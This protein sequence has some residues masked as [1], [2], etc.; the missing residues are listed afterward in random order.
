MKRHGKIAALI[1]HAVYTKLISHVY[2]LVLT[3]RPLRDPFRSLNLPLRERRISCF[4]QV[5]PEDL[6]HAVRVT[7]VVNRAALAR[8]P[9]KHELYRRFSSAMALHVGTE[10]IRRYRPDCSCRFRRRRGFL[11]SLCYCR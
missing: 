8:R 9:Y 11:Y 6:H 3:V 5:A 10:Y 1:R 2:D 4:R 7:V